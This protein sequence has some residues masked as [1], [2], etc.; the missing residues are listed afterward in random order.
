MAR[1]L[2]TLLYC[3]IWVLSLLPMPLLYLFSDIIWLIMFICPPLRYRKKIVRNNLAQSFPEKDKK[4]L[5]RTECRFYYQFLCQLMEGLKTVSASKRWVQRHMEFT[6]YEKV[7]E[8]TLKG[9]SHIGYLGHLGN[10]ELI[11]SL[12]YHFSDIEKMIGC[13]VYHKLENPTMELF[14]LKL[15]SKYGSESI[16]ME[17]VMRRLLEFRNEGRPYIIGMIADQVPLWWNTHYWTQF[18]NRKTPVFTGAER[19]A[20]KLDT[21]VWYWHIS[22]KRRGYYRC[23]I[24]LMYE[25]TKDL[26][27]F[28]VTERYMRLLEDNIK[29]C[30]EL[31]LWTHNRWKRNFEEYQEWL[32]KH[33]NADRPRN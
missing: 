29:E 32:S 23:D 1:F 5:N 9:R 31:W 12:M 27:D 20:R 3:I 22:R 18:F 21:E 16:P 7:R 6:G 2:S 25:H 24:Q 10:W 15:R 28:A 13:Q 14:M 26:P 4:W 8:E 17:H 19:L 33:Q 30:P 11:P